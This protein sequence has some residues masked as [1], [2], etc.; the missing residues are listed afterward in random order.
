MHTTDADTQGVPLAGQV[1]LVTGAGQGIGREA[2][3]SLAQLGAAVAAVDLSAPAA[4][5]TRLMIEQDGGRCHDVTADIADPVAMEQLARE[6]EA[7]LGSVDILVNNAPAFVAKPLLEHSLEEWERIVAVNLRG[8]FLGIKLFLP[9]MLQR[10]SGVVV[11]LTSGDGMP[12][13]GAY[14]ATKVALSS[15]ASSLAL[16]LG[17]DSG[18]SVFCFGPGM[19]DTPGLASVLP[20]LA[21]QYGMTVEE[22]I[23]TSAPGGELITAEVCGQGLAGCIVHAAEFHGQ[24]TS[25]AAGLARLG[26]GP[27]GE[28]TPARRARPDVGPSELPVPPEGDPW[29]EAQAAVGALAAVAEELTRECDDLGM[30][31]RQWYRRTFQRRV[32]CTIEEWQAFSQELTAQLEARG[33]RPP[34]SG[35][36]SDWAGQLQRF[37]EHMEQTQQ[38][39]RGF[40]GDATALEEALAALERR[41]STAHRLITALDR[42]NEHPPSV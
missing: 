8:A 27:T 33:D 35:E 12:F 31:Q 18:V 38:D 3:R 32:G 15:L 5:Q 39:A 37:A 25:F 6:V 11:T 19:V 36:L 1:A 13:V 28:P 9:G 2:A 23:G 4:R 14:L 16:E 34:N 29:K 41:R 21:V 22:F 42:L 17:A 24:V 10:R 40:I 26:L 7:Q 30:F 20:Q